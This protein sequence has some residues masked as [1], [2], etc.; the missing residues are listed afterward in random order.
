[1]RSLPPPAP[2]FTLRFRIRHYR[3]ALGYRAGEVAALLTPPRSRQWLHAIETA[4]YLPTLHQL[5]QLALILEVSPW[6]HLVEVVPVGGTPEALAASTAALQPHHHGPA[7][8]ATATQPEAH[9]RAA[10]LFPTSS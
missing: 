9:A 4:A 7:T 2:A 6:W 3:Y 10:L 8:T 1:M 5:V